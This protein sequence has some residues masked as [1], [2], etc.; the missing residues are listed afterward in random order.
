M[1]ALSIPSFAPVVMEISVTGS[2]TLPNRGEYVSAKAFFSRG[3]PCSPR[4]LQ[5]GGTSWRGSHS[6]WRILV[7]V[8]LCQRFLR[9]ID[10]E[11]GRVVAACEREL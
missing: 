10:E 6:C 8:H 2:I 1:I 11:P 3:R 5:L 9:C 4:Q 7:A